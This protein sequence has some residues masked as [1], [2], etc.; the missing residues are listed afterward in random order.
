MNR[1]RLPVL[2]AAFGVGA[3]GVVLAAGIGL[4]LA[5]NDRAPSEAVRVASC[6]PATRAFEARPVC[7]ARVLDAPAEAASLALDAP[8]DTIA[9]D[10][11]PVR[12]AVLTGDLD[13]IRSAVAKHNVGGSTPIVLSDDPELARRGIT[14]RA[15]YNRFAADFA[16]TLEATGG[17][18]TEPC[19]VLVAPGAIVKAGRSGDQDTAP[20][21]AR[22]LDVKAR[23]RTQSPAS[24]C[25]AQIH[26]NDPRAASPKGLVRHPDPRV[27]RVAATAERVNAEWGPAQVA[28]WAVANDATVEDVEQAPGD[29]VAY[30]DPARDVLEAAGIDT[31]KLPLYAHVAPRARRA[32]LGIDLGGFQMPRGG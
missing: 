7:A 3:S 9:D 27:A 15:R 18:T 4:V 29:Y 20:I 12:E 25:C 8:N 2:V 26:S 1:F 31:N 32:G 16:V 19:T 13:A 5:P 24:I 21:Q 23:T 6:A 28:I 22:F 17:A 30:I 14:L 11:R 10:L